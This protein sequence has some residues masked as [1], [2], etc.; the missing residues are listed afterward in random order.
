MIVSRPRRNRY[1]E[2]IR[3]LTEETHLCKADLVMPFFLIDGEKKRDAIESLP[4]V[5][6]L[7]IDNLLKEAEKF[8]SLGV[9]A[10]ALFPVIDPSKKDSV[11]SEALNEQGILPSALKVIKKEIPSLCVIADVALDPFTVHGHDGVVDST[12]Y[13]LNDKTVETLCRMAV[14]LGKSGADIVAPSDMMDGRVGA[15][16]NCLDS[17]NLENVGILSYAAKYAS[18][19]YAP[20][21]E[22]VGSALQF[23]N[24]KQYQM[25]PANSRE[26][27]R[28]AL[29]DYR[30]GADII[31]VKPALFYLDIIAQI[32]N[33]IPLP[34]AA[35]HVSGEYSMTM[36]AEKWIDPAL[37]FYESFLCIKRSGADLI[38][39]Y[40]V[41]QVLPFLETAPLGPN[42]FI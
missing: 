41:P 7:S 9:F 36:A 32:K 40:A 16:R 4:G 11:G 8:H 27:M 34:V 19:L 13:V 33:K 2:A 21:R 1:T 12:G 38:F 28:E 15:I 6:R 29:L 17:Y 22:A 35:Y 25:N 42:R 24:K 26:A 20:F 3:K 5:F 23:G 14:V 31:M 39:S 10:I 18:C 37:V 30:E